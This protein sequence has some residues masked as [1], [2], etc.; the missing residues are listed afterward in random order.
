MT[1]PIREPRRRDSQKVAELSRKVRS[2]IQ[3]C[4]FWRKSASVD[5]CAL[6]AF[7][8]HAARTRRFEDALQ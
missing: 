2:V 3:R 7:T 4:A 8:T 1:L 5:L 6:T